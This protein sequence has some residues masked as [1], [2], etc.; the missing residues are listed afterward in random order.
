[1]EKI[2][3]EYM[4][5]RTSEGYRPMDLDSTSIKAR[6]EMRIQMCHTLNYRTSKRK[7]L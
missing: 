1:M 3:L 7:A 5:C 6:P 2:A 4:S